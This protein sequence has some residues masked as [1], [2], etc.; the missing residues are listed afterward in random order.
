MVIAGNTRHQHSQA[1]RR[2]AI[3]RR[4]Q[5]AHSVN[6]PHFSVAALVLLSVTAGIPLSAAHADRRPPVQ[7][8]SHG[9]RLDLAAN[10]AS[11]QELLAALA[12]TT[13]AR[14]HYAVLPQGAIDLN[15]KSLSARDVL[16]KLF[17]TAS[18]FICIYP[19]SRR[20]AN[21]AWPSDVWIVGQLATGPQDMGRH[22]ASDTVPNPAE[23]A[24]TPEAEAET[25]KLLKQTHAADVSVRNG[26]LTSLSLLENGR[27]QE[28]AV[29]AALLDGLATG[30]EGVRGQIVYGLGS[31]GGEE[32]MVILRAGMDDPSA[33]VR[34]VAAQTVEPGSEQGRALL[35]EALNDLDENVR[36][37]A[38]EKLKSAESAGRGVNE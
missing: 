33:S 20:E 6:G 27:I 7:I 31:R 8:A 25:R 15:F 26:A 16:D 32:A 35:R 11:W 37:T 17:D 22:E 5:T 36:A 30:E 10:H 14:F 3:N 18:G 2:A 13:G 19:V 9:D 21:T 4:I 28:P 12:S 29:Q 1:P 34:Q 24:I 38:A 23:Q